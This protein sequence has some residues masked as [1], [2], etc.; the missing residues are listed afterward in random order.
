MRRR[1]RNRGTWFPTLGTHI[2]VVEDDY[3]D[4]GF[5]FETLSVP[6]SLGTGPVFY[7]PIPVTK[8]QTLNPEEVAGTAD[9]SLRDIVNGQD[10]LL[11]RLVGKIFLNVESNQAGFIPSGG[12][13]EPVTDIWPYVKV[14]AGFFV[15][16]ADEADNQVDLESY[17]SDP[18]RLDNIQNPWI[19][20][21]TWILKEP[22]AV[23]LPAG[24]PALP[25]PGEFPI[26][27]AGYGS[28]ADGPHIDSKVKRRIRREQRLWFVVA[29]SGWNGTQIQVL[30]EPGDQPEV[31]GYLDLRIFGS[32]R[33]S[34][35]DSAF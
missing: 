18:Q 6:V 24:G 15:A 33:R 20:R 14:T 16:R 3:F 21:R 1:R 30:G 7:G 26:S 8:D 13:A 2:N 29:A 11:Q 28:V 5:I 31:R 25:I 34:R 12:G 10:W 23:P 4:A 32:L 17:E 27:N 22:Q 35:N 9:V 19:W